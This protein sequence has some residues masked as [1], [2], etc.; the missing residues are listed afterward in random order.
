[1]EATSSR[2]RSVCKEDLDNFWIIFIASSRF[3]L[4]QLDYSLLISK[5]RAHNLIVN[6]I[7]HTVE[8][9][10]PQDLHM[11]Q[12]FTRIT[13][14][15]LL[16]MMVTKGGSTCLQVILCFIMGTDLNLNAS[17]E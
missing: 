8:G 9:Y 12:Q 17:K 10:R 1:M 7:F 2:F 14:G 11:E 16:V 3:I 5:S 6:Y 4:K 13:C 15:F